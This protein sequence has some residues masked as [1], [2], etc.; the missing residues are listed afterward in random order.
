MGIKHLNTYIK[1]STTCK[2]IQKLKLNEL[3][4]RI[5]AVDT[6][7]YLYK[8]LYNGELFESIYQMLSLFY[9]YNI[10]PIFVFDGKP[11]IEKLDLLKKRNEEK[12]IAELEYHNLKNLLTTFNKNNSDS[13]N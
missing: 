10:I 4:N 12:N 13:D 8:F 3:S 6:S 5:I 9:Y 7:I 1:N 2:S 11:P